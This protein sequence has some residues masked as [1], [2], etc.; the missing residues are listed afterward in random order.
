MVYHDHV[1]WDLLRNQLQ[2]NLL[3]ESGKNRGKG[4]IMVIVIREVQFDLEI[5]LTATQRRKP[6]SLCGFTHPRKAA[7]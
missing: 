3:L 5:T 1:D 4:R 7:K 6:C 2:S